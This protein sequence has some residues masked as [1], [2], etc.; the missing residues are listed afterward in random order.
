[1]PNRD[2][3]RVLIAPDVLARVLDGDA[4]LFDLTA[5]KYFGLLD[6]VGARLWALVAEGASLGAMRATLLREFDVS[7][8]VLDRDIDELFA[9]LVAAGLVRLA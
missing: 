6:P 3:L 1:M 7:P 5:G 4:I 2:D 8:E 9:A